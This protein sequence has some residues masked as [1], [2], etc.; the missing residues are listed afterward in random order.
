MEK[1][2]PQAGFFV[3]QLQTR[4]LLGGVFGGVNGTFGGV[5]S[6]FGG[7][8]SSFSSFRGFSSRCSS[9][10]FGFRR[11]R[12][13]GRSRGRSGCRSR[14]R[15]GS[16]GGFFTAG[17]QTNRQQ[18]SNK[19]AIHDFINPSKVKYVQSNLMD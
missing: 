8:G 10:S 13:G 2:G 11:F 7:I 16:R 15:C 5:N 17:D 6:A 4:L 3:M 19:E 12:R 18:G 9:R 1:A 14:S